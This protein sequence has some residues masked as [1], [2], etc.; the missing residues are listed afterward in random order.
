M[1]AGPSPVPDYVRQALAFQTVGHMDPVFMHIMEEVSGLLRQVFRTAN[2][3]TF[4]VSATGS[5]GMELMLCNLVEPGDRVI[6]GTCGVFGDRI[7]DAL[8]RI[9]A[10]VIR[11]EGRW[12]RAIPL[13]RLHG[14]AAD[15]FDAMVLVHGETSTGVVQPL[16]G[17][18]ELC[19]ERDALLLVDCVT[20]LGGHSLD[21]DLDGVDAAFSGSQKC[22]NCPPGLSPFTLGERAIRRIVTPSRSW[23]F[24]LTAILEYWS[25]GDTRRIYHHTAPV[26]MVFALWA[27]LEK[28]VDEG[29]EKRWLR[30]ARAHKALS[31]ALAS[32]GLERL[33]QRTKRYT[34]PEEG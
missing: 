27:A 30:H 19:R 22:L 11:V 34:T 6:C 10:D 24:D 7:A 17:L 31:S 28:I 16:D 32:L 20:S 5:G 26:N 14:A 8:G 21:I 29:L 1:G 15:R 23:Y 18:S 12:G 13:D 4:P 33:F 3:A 2:Q 25:E 9:G